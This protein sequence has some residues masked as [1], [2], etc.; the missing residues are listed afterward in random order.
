MLIENRGGSRVVVDV[1]AFVFYEWMCVDGKLCNMPLRSNQT[2]SVST[3]VFMGDACRVSFFTLPDMSQSPVN[4]T[5]I[6]DIE[7]LSLSLS[8]M[9][10]I[11]T[12][13]QHNRFLHRKLV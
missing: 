6:R 4:P 9:L 5:Y 8:S 3:C 12:W 13:R 1:I 10:D 11:V 2:T 7:T